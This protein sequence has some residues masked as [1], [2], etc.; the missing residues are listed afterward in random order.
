MKPLQQQYIVE[1]YHKAVGML[2]T[3]V[4]I[5]PV[6]AVF[7]LTILQRLSFIGSPRISESHNNSHFALYRVIELPSLGEVNIMCKTTILLTSSE[8]SSIIRRCPLT[9]VTSN[10]TVSSLIKLLHNGSQVV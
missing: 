1:I 8:I 10:L 6:L 3:C 9:L 4:L 7:F 2:C 5:E